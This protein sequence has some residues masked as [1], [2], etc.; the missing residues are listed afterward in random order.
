MPNYKNSTNFKDKAT[1]APYSAKAPA[2]TK[3]AK[4]ENNYLYIAENELGIVKVGVTKNNPYDRVESFSS[5]YE[6]KFK[7]V[8][9]FNI[10]NMDRL[11]VETFF[12]EILNSQFLN[13]NYLAKKMPQINPEHKNIVDNR[14]NGYTELFV[15]NKTILKNM[16]IFLNL[17][18]VIDLKIYDIHEINKIKPY[19]LGDVKRFKKSNKKLVQAELG[20]ISPI[21]PLIN[22]KQNLLLR[23]AKFFFKNLPSNELKHLSF[24]I[25][26]EKIVFKLKDKEL[27][28]TNFI[29][30]DLSLE[31][32]ESLI[33]TKTYKNIYFKKLVSHIANLRV[34]N[35]RVS[36]QF[37]GEK[38]EKKEFPSAILKEP[39]GPWAR[40]SYVSESARENGRRDVNPLA[41]KKAM[42]ILE[43]SLK[44]KNSANYV[45]KVSKSTAKKLEDPNTLIN[46][47][48]EHIA[49]IEK[50]SHMINGASKINI[51]PKFKSTIPNF[52]LLNPDGTVQHAA[53]PV[54]K[55][56]VNYKKKM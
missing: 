9:Y 43:A 23:N 32:T 37:N 39:K 30:T 36:T 38:Q 53:E 6:N 1:N 12:H 21:K 26:D 29:Y 19:E 52:I 40:S 17:I 45:S 11:N 14:L 41:T 44:N 35:A 42:E 46:T 2:F 27:S 49:P 15:E 22:N 16:L 48:G 47:K 50:N 5:F 4:V 51:S 3:E 13:I 18:D 8:T 55:K 7:L 56:W 24:D 34:L 33:K 20:K 25:T 31:L 54:K 10:K 28:I